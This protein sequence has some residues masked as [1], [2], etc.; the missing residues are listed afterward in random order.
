MLNTKNHMGKI[1]VSENYITEI[2][3]HAVCEC[4]GVSDVCSKNK[5][6]SALSAITNS[7]FFKR[8]GVIIRKDDDGIIIDLHIKVTYGVNIKTAVD[9]IINKIYSA[10]G[11]TAGIKISSV[12]VFVDDM[13]G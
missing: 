1:S 11:E 5:I 10:V 9:S 12:N 8:R 4:F 7:K 2:V 3:R 6:R 13:N